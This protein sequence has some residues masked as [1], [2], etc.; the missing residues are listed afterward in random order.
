MKSLH[1]TYALLTASLCAFAQ[2]LS[3]PATD[4]AT[5]WRADLDLLART[6]RGETSQ[7]PLK[8]FDRLY[9]PATFNTSIDDLK[10]QAPSLSDEELTLGLMRLIASAHV[11]HNSIA[12]ASPQS[13]TR[14]PFSLEWLG[15][16]LVIIAATGQYA[17]LNGAEVLRF[18]PLSSTEF[19]DQLAPYVSYESRSWLLVKS[20]QY[21]V[22]ELF[23]RHFH[24]VDADNRVPLTLRRP[25]SPEFARSIPFVDFA[26]RRIPFAEARHLAPNLAESHPGTIYWSQYLP[27]SETYF[28]Q[29]NACREDPKLSFDRFVSQV[30]SDLDA[31]AV[32]RVVLDLRHN[33]GGNSEIINPLIAALS[34]RRH[35]VGKIYVLIGPAVF[36]SGLMDAGYLKHRLKAIL[37]GEPT[38]G[39]VDSYGELSPLKLSASGV[40]VY[41]STKHFGAHEHPK[42]A[43]KPGIAAAAT[44]ESFLAHRDLA[45]EA[46]LTAK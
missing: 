35:S 33:G 16:H 41:Y 43:L 46:A 37:V 4:R 31:H 13:S 17:D 21:M 29:Y 22:Q 39:V 12:P 38:G 23:L 26:D 42:G 45:L 14:L 30:A 8:D 15:G 10:R 19:L 28:I 7:P 32:R 44:Y 2:T 3:A 40:S 34:Q 9:P 5:A 25:G 36:S 11:A 6:F 27:G 18:G 1:L 20:G 24:L